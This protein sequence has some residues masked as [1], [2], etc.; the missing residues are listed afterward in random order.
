M[1]DGKRYGATPRAPVGARLASSPG[2]GWEGCIKSG[3]VLAALL[4]GFA[5]FAPLL[6]SFPPHGPPLGGPG[7][8]RWRFPDAERLRP[9]PRPLPRVAPFVPLALS[10]AGWAAFTAAPPMLPL[11]ARRGDARM[12]GGR[13]AVANPQ[14]WPPARLSYS[15]WMWEAELSAVATPPT[16]PPA[17]FYGSTRM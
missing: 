14:T 6:P 3:A 17:I 16:W 9:P 8:S 5:S 2:G 7:M 15:T 1:A 4:R 10:G 12:R 11:G 13:S